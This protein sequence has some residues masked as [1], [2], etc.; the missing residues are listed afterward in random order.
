MCDFKSQKCFC[1]QNSNCFPRTSTSL[2]HDPIVVDVTQAFVFI[3]IQ[4]DQVSP[5]LH[6]IFDLQNSAYQAQPDCIK[7]TSTAFYFMHLNLETFKFNRTANC[8]NDSQWDRNPL[9]IFRISILN[10][11]YSFCW[12]HL[13]VIWIKR[14]KV[15]FKLLIKLEFYQIL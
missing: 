15:C 1:C 10:K 11:Y 7:Y 3:S 12:S 6:T 5:N 2:S 9:N 14:D 4:D 8:L 13:F